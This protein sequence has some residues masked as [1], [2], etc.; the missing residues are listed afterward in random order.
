M[1][2]ETNEVQ[3]FMPLWIADYLADT[4]HLT[5]LQ[6]GAYDLLLY[7]YW[8]RGSPLPD[9]N[10]RFQAI[11]K[12]T[13]AEWRKLRPVLAEF[14][15]LA[16]GVWTQKRAETELAKARDRLAV[17]RQ[18][19]EAA[20]NARKE[21]DGSRK[22][23]VTKTVTDDVTTDVTSNVTSN[24]TSTTSPSPSPEE[25][26]GSSMEVSAAVTA[27]NDAARQCGWPVAKDITAQRRVG[28]KARIRQ[29]GGIEGWQA[30]L[31]RARASPFLRG[32]TGRS[33]G[34]ENWRPDLEFFLKPAKF[35]KLLEGGYDGNPSAA[36]A[37]A[38]GRGKPALADDFMAGALDALETLEGGGM[39]P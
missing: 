9:D 30:A 11:T 13:P 23:D 6:H 10:V 14:F 25:P 1:T 16:D 24:V 29:A 36:A 18:R 19:T 28:L 20:T 7:A 35:T 34:H 31:S 17:Q 3:G 37:R 12:T 32:E 39:A 4:T 27:Y 22:R 2:R 21:R 26:D 38:G 15:I 8:R 33:A 5:T